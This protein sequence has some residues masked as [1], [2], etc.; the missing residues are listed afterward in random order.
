MHALLGGVKKRSWVLKNL[1]PQK[2]LGVE[3]PETPK[4]LG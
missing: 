4:A 2:E 3:R 1:E